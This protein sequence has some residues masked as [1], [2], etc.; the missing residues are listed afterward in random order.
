[1]DL[2]DVCG[3][4]SMEIMKNVEEYNETMKKVGEIY[5]EEDNDYI[6]KVDPYKNIEMRK[7][8]AVETLKSE[9]N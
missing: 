1:M 9:Y 4:H 5:E 2:V 8:L 3:E 6:G 7:L